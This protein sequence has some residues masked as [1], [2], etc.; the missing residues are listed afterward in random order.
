MVSALGFGVAY[1]FDTDNG[2]ARREQLRRSL[3]RTVATIDSVLAPEVG[4]PPPV[5][6]PLLRGLGAE[7][8]EPRLTQRSEA[9]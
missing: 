6:F 9:S 2:A 4:D 3:R 5:F 1:F 7:E 8:A